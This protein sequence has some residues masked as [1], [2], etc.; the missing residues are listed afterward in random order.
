MQKIYQTSHAERVSWFPGLIIIFLPFLLFRQGPFAMIE[1]L[2][3]N[4]W[5][6]TQTAMTVISLAMAG[7]GLRLILRWVIYF[8]LPFSLYLEAT[9]LLLEQLR[10]QC[11]ETQPPSPPT[12]ALTFNLPSTT[13]IQ[14]TRQL[15]AERDKR[16]RWGVIIANLFSTVVLLLFVLNM[17]F[18]FSFMVFMDHP[19]PA[20]K[21]LLFLLPLF[22][23]LYAI[24]LPTSLW[25][26]RHAR[27]GS[28]IMAC[29]PLI[30]LLLICII[31]F[32]A[33]LF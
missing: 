20:K 1:T 10:K 18:F 15:W 22:V 7:L 28:F 23:V 3:N 2:I 8:R 4:P 29:V 14:A 17:R 26:L 9:G 24:A 30:N 27:L 12:A 21:V 19:S 6:H 5:Q 16:L 33:N 11:L 25:L 31:A 13:L 32:F